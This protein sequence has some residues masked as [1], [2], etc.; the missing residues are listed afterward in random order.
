MGVLLSLL[1]QQIITPKQGALYT[2]YY[3]AIINR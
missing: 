1:M 2:A 3:P